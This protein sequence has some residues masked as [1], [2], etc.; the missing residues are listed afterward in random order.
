MQRA[1]C[2]LIA[3]LSAPCP[4][5][6]STRLKIAI[7]GLSL[8]DWYKMALGITTALAS[9]ELTG[10]SSTQIARSRFGVLPATHIQTGAP[11]CGS[12]TDCAQSRTQTM[13]SEHI[14][15]PSHTTRTHHVLDQVAGLTQ[16]P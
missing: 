5:M 16:E 1:C 9:D 13:A 2:H 6:W 4:L 7:K 14:Q 12:L 3:L 10:T 15:I 11:S 8:Q